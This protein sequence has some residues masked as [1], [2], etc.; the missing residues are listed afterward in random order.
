M[1]SFDFEYYRPAAIA[2][3]VNI[4]YGLQSHGKEALYYSGGT[5]I[6]SMARSNELHFDAVVDI[7]EIPECNVLQIQNGQLAIGA[8]ATLTGI[9]EAGLFPL[10]ADV[11][12]ALSDHT[13]RNKI[14]VGGNIC[15]IIEYREALLPFLLCDSL[16]V[17]AGRNGMR[18][19]PI[20]QIFN[21]RLEIEKGE[22]L[23]QLVTDKSFLS[24]PHKL[25]RRTA[26][27]EIDYPLVTIAMVI[28]DNMVRAA[29]SGICGYPF[30]S[31][32]IEED[33]NDGSIIVD[34]R[35]SNAIRHLPAP[36]LNDLRGSAEYREYI[37]R[38]ALSDMIN[39]IGGAA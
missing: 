20:N 24:L 14:T 34:A 2:E 33:L 15:G 4:Y 19:V 27:E 6:I 31:S 38:N 39:S 18:T 28:K 7:K 10:L 36:L 30:R 3:A 29:F 12:R 22:L 11:S 35:I 32:K 16:A 23:V 1:I 37:L 8:A 26:I 21:Q 25:F 5:E 9:C 17:L 13:S